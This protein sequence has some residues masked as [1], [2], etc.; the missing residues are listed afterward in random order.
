MRTSLALKAWLLALV[1]GGINSLPLVF[2]G[3][4]A[5]P[6]AHD[7]SWSG[8]SSSS[9]DVR[10]RAMQAGFAERTRL[11]QELVDI[12]SSRPEDSW[13]ADDERMVAVSL[14]P[15]IGD[16]AAIEFLIASIDRLPAGVRNP[17]P[18]DYPC[19]R[20]LV[21]IGRPASRFAAN[22]VVHPNNV[23]D[24]PSEHTDLLIYVV[25]AIEGEEFGEAYI[26]SEACRSIT[27]LKVRDFLL[28]RAAERRLAKVA[29]GKG[30]QIRVLG[31]ALLEGFLN[32]GA[33][34]FTHD[35]DAVRLMFSE[36]GSPTVAVGKFVSNTRVADVLILEDGIDDRSLETHRGKWNG[37]GPNGSGPSSH[38]L[39]GQA[40]ALVAS[41]T[42]PIESLSIAQ[43]KAV[44]EGHAR[45]WAAI[46]D[47]DPLSPNPLL[48]KVPEHELKAYGLGQT[49]KASRIFERLVLERRHWSGVTPIVDS[50]RVVAAVKNDPGALAFIDWSEVLQGSNDVKFVPIKPGDGNHAVATLPSRATISNG[51]Y[52]LSN[53]FIA[54]IHPD[55]SASAKKFVHYLS[56]VGGE[57][58]CGC[59]DTTQVVENIFAT[60]RIVPPPTPTEEH[61]PRGTKAP[62]A[63]KPPQ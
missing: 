36:S 15:D 25:T 29:A 42:N 58:A 55:A 19:V 44:F 49:A 39:G 48:G 18:M 17:K 51:D 57:V 54:Y 52:A 20:A 10:R 38:L 61:S 53:R 62:S 23:V 59:R 30:M 40:V 9:P 21:K 12:A 11:S 45:N 7:E 34:A 63:K 3:E 60:H 16:E 28:R 41:S 56:S 13:Q 43:V 37:L 27:H 2:A 46:A 35:S 31:P 1:V 22:A 26:E 5:E 33:V 6:S 32:D 47:G 24:E 4:T 14:L 8:L 50:S